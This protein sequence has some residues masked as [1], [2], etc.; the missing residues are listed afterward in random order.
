MTV[1]GASIS[2]LLLIGI[3]F[4]GGI[5]GAQE[6]AVPTSEPA[7]LGPPL[8]GTALDR[9]TEEV[10]SLLR[11]PVCQGLSVADSPASS[12]VDLKAEVRRQLAAGYTRDQVVAA[13]E[14]SYGEFIRLEP[15][16]EGFNWL[17]WLMPILALVVGAVVIFLRLRPAHRLPADGGPHPPSTAKP[18]SK[19]S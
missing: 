2:L 10:S 6:P 19:T 7:P 11:C 16:A 3:V 8:S 18:E 12:A 15:K 14:R 17:V 13:F 4:S 9:A 5:A 1:R